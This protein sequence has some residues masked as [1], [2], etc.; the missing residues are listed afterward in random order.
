MGFVREEYGIEE[1]KKKL[2][3]IGYKWGVHT[4]YWVIDK[5]K[6]IILVYS[7]KEHE[8]PF[9]TYWWLYVEGEWHGITTED[10]QLVGDNLYCRKVVS[11]TKPEGIDKEEAKALI[12]DIL[13]Y[14]D[15]SRIRNKFNR[16]Y[17]YRVEV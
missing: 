8:E 7:V 16:E 15:N 1:L 12:K 4:S 14:Q 2:Y 5:E 13:E 17:I 9:Y 3:E 6:D 10:P 11:Y